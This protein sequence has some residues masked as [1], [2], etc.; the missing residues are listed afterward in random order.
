MDITQS[1]TDPCF[2]VSTLFP[3]EETSNV[4]SSLSIYLHICTLLYNT[5]DTV[6]VLPYYFPLQSTLKNSPT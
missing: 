5:Y 3:R 1:M 2:C 6:V 4:R